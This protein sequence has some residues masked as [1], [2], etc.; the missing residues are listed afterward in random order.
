MINVRCNG[1]EPNLWNCSFTQAN[2]FSTADD[3]GVVCSDHIPIRLVDGESR[4]AGRVEVYYNETW[5]TVCDDSWD[6]TVAQVA[7]KQLKCGQ[8]VNATVSG[9]FGPGSGIIWLDNLNCSA[10]DSALWECRR[11]PWGDSDCIHKEDAGVICSEHMAIRLE[12][13]PSRCQGRVEVFYNG[14]WGSVCSDSFG[15]E[16]AEVICNQQ[17]CGSARS[18]HHDATFGKSSGPIWL[19]DVKCRSHDSLLWQCPSSPWGQHDC[20]H[21]EDVG[22]ICSGNKLQMEPVSCGTFH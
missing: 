6:L 12:N 11:G 22:V 4:C 17:G 21:L 14:T 3:V 5:G 15:L 13:G 1:S 18:V 20:S 16:E 9:W 19:D 10:N 2:P 7:C 8:A